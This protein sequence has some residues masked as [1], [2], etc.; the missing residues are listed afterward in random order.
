VF[1]IKELT[2]SRTMEL[3]WRDAVRKSEEKPFRFEVLADVTMKRSAF[4]A[5]TPCSPDR[6]SG[7]R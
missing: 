7:S 2:S 3:N 6:E 5:A 1:F 4:C